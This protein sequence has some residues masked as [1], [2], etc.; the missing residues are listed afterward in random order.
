MEN[1]MNTVCKQIHKLCAC[2][3]KPK[4]QMIYVHHNTHILKPTDSVHIKVSHIRL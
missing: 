3:S 4:C 1:M 2:K